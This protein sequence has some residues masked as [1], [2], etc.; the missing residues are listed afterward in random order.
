MGQKQQVWRQSL[1]LVLAI[2]SVLASAPN[3]AF[4]APAAYPGG[5]HWVNVPVR[6]ASQASLGM[7]G[8]EGGQC[9][10]GMTRCASDDSRLYMCID[11][12]GVWRSDN[13]GAFWRPCRSAGLFNNGNTAI[14]VSPVNHDVV[15]VYSQENW[16]TSR[17]G[18]EGIYRSTNGGD[19]W[20]RTLAVPNMDGN[21]VPHPTLAFAFTGTRVYLGSFANG[22]YRSDDG[23]ATWTGPVSL[24]TTTINRVSVDPTNAN[25]VWAATSNGVQVSTDS[26]ATWT[27]KAAS[28]VNVPDVSADPITANRVYY[29]LPGSGL[30]R[31]NDG[32]ATWALVSCGDA[33]INSGATRLFQSPINS[34]YMILTSGSSSRA[35]IDGGATWSSFTVDTSRTYNAPTGWN[36]TG[37]TCYSYTTPGSVVG[38]NACLVYGSANG[39]V[40]WSDSS[41]GFTGFYHQWSQTAMAFSATDPNR[42]AMFCDDMNTSLTFDN[43]STWI[44]K[45]LAAQVEGWWGS[46]AGDMSPN[47]ATTPIIV[48][49]SG[50]YFHDDIMRTSTGTTSAA[51]WANVNVANSDI[52]FVRFSQQNANLV[53]ADNLR[54][55]DA[56]ATWSPLAYKVRGMAP[57]NGSIVYAYN[58]AGGVVK[59]TDA[60]S[61]WSALP[62][63]PASANGMIIGVDPSNTSKIWA[64]VG[65]DLAMFNGTSWTSYPAST[66]VSSTLAPFVDRVAV[67]PTNGNKVV[68]GLDTVGTS[69]LFATTDGGTTWYDI[70]GDAPQIGEGQ[71]LNIQ[72]VTGRIFIGHAWGTYTTYLGAPA[73]G[74]VTAPSAPGSLASPSQTTASANLTWSASTDNVAVRAYDVYV[75]G[76]LS[77]T[78]TGTSWTVNGLSTAT[79]YAFKVVAR[80]NAGNQ[81]SSSVLNV[82][83]SSNIPAAPS[84]LSAVAGNAQVTLSWAASSGATAYTVKRSTVSGSGY[85]NVATP[86]A[87]SYTN[88][89]LTNGTTYYFVVSAGNAGGSSA[90]SSQV[91]AVPSATSANAH[92]GTWAIKAA[93][94]PTYVWKNVWQAPTGVAPGSTYTA[95]FWMKGSGGITLILCNGSWGTEI[96][97]QAFTATST[98]AQYSYTVSTGTNTQLTYD[99]SDGAVTT[100][101]VYVDDCFL[102]VSG[103]A[104]LIVNPGFESG[105]A[106]WF[107]D[108]PSAFS[109]MQNPT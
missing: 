51:D 27:V 88:T 81:T 87:T 92:G 15:L 86:A 40:N 60:G 63:P 69:Y 109:I 49:A 97:R 44:T 108:S 80:D 17:G 13:G 43:G 2:A 36:L 102:G 52:K 105:A 35:T 78:T 8:G 39:G 18:L 53:Y 47:W 33:T 38:A 14:A 12:A 6:S 71:S 74:D 57:S 94:T 25:K 59:S 54:S 85:A 67:D 9:L 28:G 65:S 91:S 55:N 50:N 11:M 89:G 76:A 30:Q 73:G 37:G 16:Q 96:K 103:G 104:N 70:T 62:A 48:N 93:F 45:K 64:V 68:V 106:S 23:G 101:T 10:T 82:S 107:P 4:A 21:A 5:V 77:G 32:G 72:P 26:G 99:L 41:A 66:W 7:N 83:T 61:T 95:S 31:S 90:N 79:Q 19:T 1:S 3:G 24:T 75:G 34:S 84:G 58:G 98:W 42:W 22:L 46:Y 29:I 20:T 56:G 100:G